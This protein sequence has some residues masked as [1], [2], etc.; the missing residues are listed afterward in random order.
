MV[1]RQRN[2]SG[3]FVQKSDE[4]RKVRSIRLTDR[5][6]NEL[7]RIVGERDITRADLME[8]LIEKGLAELLK[9]KL[10][11]PKQL[12]LPFSTQPKLERADLEEKRDRVLKRSMKELKVGTS[13]APYRNV[14]KALDTFIKMLL[15]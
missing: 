12:E 15:D 14:K 5:A 4:A 10:E 3:K 2:E 1:E 11:S 8:E 9:D 6:W 7:G 13:S